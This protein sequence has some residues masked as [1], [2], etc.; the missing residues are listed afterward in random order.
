MRVRKKA[1]KP[2]IPL[3]LADWLDQESSKNELES[4]SD[5]VTSALER[6]RKHRKRKGK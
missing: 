3:E 6:E 5:I 1:I 4:K 2:Y